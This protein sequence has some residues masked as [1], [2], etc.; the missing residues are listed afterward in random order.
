ITSGS[1]PEPF[2]HPAGVPASA[3]MEGS[4]L[5]QEGLDLERY[6]EWLGQRPMP[7]ALQRT[8]GGQSP[9][10][11]PPPMTERPLPY[12]AEKDRRRREEE[13]VYED[14]LPAP[15]LESAE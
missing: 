15:T 1:L 11:R 3:A 9:A 14:D 12:Y 8:N 7:Q 6:L 10:A 13:E 4:D 5:P 2:L